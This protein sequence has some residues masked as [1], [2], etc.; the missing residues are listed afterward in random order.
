M[1]FCSSGTTKYVT[2]CIIYCSA[3][4]II[5]CLDPLFTFLLNTFSL[6]SV[7]V[8]PQYLFLL[9]GSTYSLPTSFNNLLLMWEW[10]CKFFVSLRVAKILITSMGDGKCTLR[11][12]MKMEMNI[13]FHSHLIKMDKCHLITIELFST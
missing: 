1:A 11:C 4:V 10:I 3:G 12:N 5:I 13:Y 9:L 6:D 2:F 8:E 7:K